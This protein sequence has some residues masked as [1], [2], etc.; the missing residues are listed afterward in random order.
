[1]LCRGTVV[2]QGGPASARLK[3]VPGGVCR[4]IQHRHPSHRCQ[5]VSAISS[6][7][8]PAAFSIA[9]PAFRTYEPST[10]S[11]NNC[12]ECHLTCWPNLRS[13]LQQPLRSGRPNRLRLRLDRVPPTSQAETSFPSLTTRTSSTRR[14]IRHRLQDHPATLAPLEAWPHSLRQDKQHLVPCQQRRQHR[15]HS[16][17]YHQ[18]RAATTTMKMMTGATLPMPHQLNH[19]QPCPL[20]IRPRLRP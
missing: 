12:K 19:Q 9:S 10:R 11:G 2:R 14:Q 15:P 18:L 3:H 7:V 4:R 5:C 6:N 8:H 13:L 20:R 16:H 17:H 1:M